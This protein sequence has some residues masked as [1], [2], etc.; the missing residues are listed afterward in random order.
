MP[1][2]STRVADE[3][4]ADLQGLVTSGY[5]HLPRAAYLFVRFHDASAARRWIGKLLG[6]ITSGRPWPVAADGR[7]RKPSSAVNLAFTAPGLTACGVPPAVHCTFPPEFREGIAVP[8]RSR[9]LG[10]TGESAPARWELGGPANPPLHA[11]V[12]V[13]A[14]T[15]DELETVCTAQR[16]LIAESAGGVGELPDSMQRGYRPANDREPFGFR[17]GIAQPDIAG[18]AGRGVPT[19]E[20]ILGY[21]NHYGAVPPTPV[22]S[23]ELDPGGILPPLANPYHAAGALRDLGKN[24]TFVVYRKLQQDVAAFWQFM[25]AEA[26]RIH[27]AADPAFMVW[28]ASKC[29]GRWPSGAPLALS[30]D[31]DDARL[32]DRDDFRYGDDPDGL[33]CPVGAHVRRANPR[34][35]IRPNG[36]QQS[37]GMSEAHRLLRRGRVFGPPPAPA[38]VPDEGRP[39]G[40]H[41]L[42]VNASIRSQF[43]FVQQTWCNNPHFSGLRDNRDPLVGD[44]AGPGQ[45]PSHMT[46]PRRPTLLRTS[47][48]PRFV[49]VRAGAYLFLPSLTTLRFLAG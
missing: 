41:F 35:A 14:A 9:I 31:A 44:S 37:L 22:V 23:A 47:A 32:A 13:H 25:K 38:A 17:D 16:R 8:H 28:L 2:A 34:D 11:V 19:G 49:T 1:Q 42:C 15:D 48:V 36:P 29:V 21:E 45:P 33:A 39:R 46:I 24:G 7:K 10:D 18:I 3:V 43:E 40:I 4:L 26:T 30:P 27:G 5:G 6:S 20:F 12:V